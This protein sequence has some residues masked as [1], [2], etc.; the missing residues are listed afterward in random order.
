MLNKEKLLILGA[1]GHGRASAYV[2]ASMKRWSQIAFLNDLT[3]PE[4]RDFE[5]LGGFQEVYRYKEEYDVFVAIG[6]NETRR[7]LLLQLEAENFTI[8]VL[9]HP[10]AFVGENVKLGA[11]S[12]VMAGAVIICNSTI[13]KGVIVNTS[14][15]IDHDNQIGDFVHISPGAHLA[16]E[17]TIGENT[18]I[19]TGAAVINKLTITDHCIVG[20]GAVVVR[21]ITEKGTYVGVPARRI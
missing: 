16:G 14:S 15:S 19:C 10:S 7:K 12:I 2:A 20:A 3:I 9:I 18:W 13:G 11:G 4:L 1:G 8:P 6:D 17:V 21:A 5:I